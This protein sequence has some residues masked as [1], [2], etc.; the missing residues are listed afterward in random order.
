MNG[1][2]GREETQ[3]N[4]R[5]AKGVENACDSPWPDFVLRAEFSRNAGRESHKRIV[6]VAGWLA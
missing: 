2:I 4:E 6:P 5:L 3:R 1:L